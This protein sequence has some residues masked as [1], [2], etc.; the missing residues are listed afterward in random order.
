MLLPWLSWPAWTLHI[1][2]SWYRIPDSR[3][4]SV[5]VEDGDLGVTEWS[6]SVDQSADGRR[7]VALFAIA[8]TRAPTLI[9]LFNPVMRRFLVT[10]LPAG[11]NVL[12]TL[13]GRKTG[14]PR[15]FPVAF[16]DLGE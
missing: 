12:L 11:P 3:Q 6:G 9:R 13:R 15:S 1:V 5:G 8:F 2:V 16:L 4:T 14:L 10:G 7:R